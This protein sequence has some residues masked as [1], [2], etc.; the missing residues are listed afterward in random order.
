ND[1]SNLKTDVSS[2]KTDVSSLKTDVSTLK[3]DVS[4]LKN[5]VSEMK[6]QLEENTDML[7]VLL[8]N[9]ETHGAEIKQLNYRVAK[10]EGI[11][12]RQD[13]LESGLLNHRHEVVFKIGEAVF[14]D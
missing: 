10:I 2:L 14:D 13:K 9:S 8:A 3:T 6:P 7:R 5:D 11:N 1:V 12:K 4:S